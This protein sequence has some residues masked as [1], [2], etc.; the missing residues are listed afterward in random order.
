MKKSVRNILVIVIIAV[1]LLA[2]FMVAVTHNF[3]TEELVYNQS[4]DL[5]AVTVEGKELTLY[6]LA[7]YVGY[8]EQ[9]INEQAMIYD[10][11][12][13]Q[14]Y[15]NIHTNGEFLRVT[16]RKAAVDMMVHD[17]VYSTEATEQG[18]TLSKEEKAACDSSAEDFWSD[19]TEDQ[20]E[21]LGIP[22]EKVY[23]VCTQIGLSEKYLMQL[24][25]AE[26]R[27]LAVYETGGVAWEEKRDSM[28]IVYNDKVLDRIEMGTITL[29]ID[30]TEEETETGYGK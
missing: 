28:N 7:F 11:E 21:A 12:H 29:D 26:G 9:K 25:A 6:D 30:Y 15:W 20:R 19:L 23:E 16:A 13:P 5:T 3:F 27:D 2:L 14:R 24:S 22:M 10:P 4:L 8:E 17:Y 18:I 1:A